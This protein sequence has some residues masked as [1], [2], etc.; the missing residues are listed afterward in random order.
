VVFDNLFAN[1]ELQDHY[2]DVGHH[3]LVQDAPSF[4]HPCL[5]FLLHLST[6]QRNACFSLISMFWPFPGLLVPTMTSASKNQYRPDFEVSYYNLIAVYIRSISSWE[7]NNYCP[8][9]FTRK[10]LR[11][12]T[13]SHTLVLTNEFLGEFPPVVLVLVTVL[14]LVLVVV[15]ALTLVLG[16]VLVLVPV[17]VPVVVS[18]LVLV[19]AQVLVLVLLLVLAL[20][21]VLVLVLVLVPVHA[22]DAVHLVLRCAPASRSSTCIPLHVVDAVPSTHFPF[23]LI[24]GNIYETM[25]LSFLIPRM[26]IFGILLLF[27]VV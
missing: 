23:V 10:N 11:N 22:A 6:A 20:A 17:S 26:K 8:H 25:H 16:L 2:G 3:L 4:I 12:Q 27:D 21:L 5:V 18:A 15:L 14:V 19:L 13:S 9:E 7:T 1:F 24:H